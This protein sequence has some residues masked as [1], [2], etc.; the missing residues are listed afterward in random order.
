[1]LYLIG[2]GLNENS[3]S[4]EGLG[5]LGKCKRVYLE[6]YTV[7]FPYKIDELEKNF[8]RKLDILE[9]KEVESD[10]LVK[11]AKKEDIALLVYGC[12]LF[13]TTH[14][15]LLMEAKKAKVKTRV[16]YAASV[17]DAV[18]ESGLELYKFGKIT[19]MPKWQGEKFRP[20]SFM[21]I[22]K[23]NES[24]GAH[25]LILTDIG[26]KLDEA[27]S[28]LE[29]SASEKNIK[30]DKIVVASRLGTEENKFFYDNPKKFKTKRVSAPFCIIIPASNLHFLEKEALEKL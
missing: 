17:F 16:I 20:M 30:L 12:P 5:V 24:I 21:D 22:V 3:I 7:D 11:E 29:A 4:W 14:L 8:G 18:A 23:Q 15:S 25:S 27:I 1:M 2:L 28:E 9:R 13:A 26:L 19:S 10:K 6:G